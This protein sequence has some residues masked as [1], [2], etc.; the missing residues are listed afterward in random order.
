MAI[1]RLLQIGFINICTLIIVLSP[2]TIRNYVTFGHFIPLRG[3]GGLELALANHPIAVTADDDKRVF[4][5]RLD[6]IH[7]NDSNAAFKKMMTVGGEYEYAR[8]LQNK[9]VRWITDNPSSFFQLALKHLWQFYFPPAW[10][11]DVYGYPGKFILLKQTISWMIALIGLIGAGLAL[12]RW[13][14]KLAYLAILV[15]APGLVYMSFQPILRYRYLVF[16]PLL[17]LGCEAVARYVAR[18][19]AGK[20]FLFAAKVPLLWERRIED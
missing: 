13:R 11:W 4:R 5:A 15:I 18:V 10:L 17:F 1:G 20:S 12:T 3:N 7:P 8:I 6:E 16:A 9:S 19:A 14:D 2:W